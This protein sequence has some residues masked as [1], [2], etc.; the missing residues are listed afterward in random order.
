MTAEAKAAALLPLV[1]AAAAEAEVWPTLLRQLAV[2]LAA[3]GLLVGH[4][5]P[6]PPAAGRVWAHG[7]APAGVAAFMRDGVIDA[8]AFATGLFVLAPEPDATVLTPSGAAGP[9]LR[10]GLV[11]ALQPARP[12]SEPIGRM[13]RQSG[14]VWALAGF[15]QPGPATREAGRRQL[16]ETLL[17][18]LQRAAAVQARLA[19]LQ[20]DARLLA[21][22]LERLSLGVIALAADLEVVFANAVAEAMLGHGDGLH[23]ANGRLTLGEPTLQRRL[24]A[25]V[26]AAAAGDVAEAAVHLFVDRPSGGPP[27]TLC[28]EPAGFGTDGAAEA[29]LAGAAATLFV[30]DPARPAA[31]PPVELLAERFSLTASEAAVARLAALGRG[32]P[33]VADALGLSLNT[34]R[35]HLKAVYGK[36]A[37]NHQAGLA[38][39]VVDSFPPFRQPHGDSPALTEDG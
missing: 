15:R 27:Y 9:P 25:A 10:P 24:R 20:H 11:I 3:D 7:I 23:R 22:T 33:F 12:L 19:R 16:L 39:L 17:P 21:T 4:L 26:E 30:T 36:T 37:V 29:V 32:M 14:A 8:A 18:H 2:E 28:L 34:V 38:R 1:Y 5:P 6:M 35:T 31:A 13:R